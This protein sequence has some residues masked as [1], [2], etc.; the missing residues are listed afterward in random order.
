MSLALMEA[1]TTAIQ[2]QIDDIGELI[3]GGEASSFES[4]RHQTGILQG[5]ERARA[6]VV[7]TYRSLFERD[8]E[9]GDDGDES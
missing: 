9:G 3:L 4:Y 5:L 7:D 6:L 8:E 2:K 1:A